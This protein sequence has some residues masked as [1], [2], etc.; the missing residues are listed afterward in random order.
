VDGAN[1]IQR[2]KDRDPAALAEIYVRYQPA[3]YRCIFYRVGDAGTA[4]DLTGEV[5]VRLVENMDRFPDQDGQ[6]LA[7]LCSIA[8][9]LTSDGHRRTGRSPPLASEEGNAGAIHPQEATEQRLSPQHLAAAIARL[10]DDQSQAVLL[11]FLEGLDNETVA[12]VLGQPVDAVQSLQWQALA[13]LTAALACCDAT[14]APQRSGPREEELERLQ[15][16]FTQNVAHELRTPLTLIQGYNEL[17]LTGTLGPL[18]SEQQ[19]ALEVVC[20]RIEELSRVIHSL[21]FTRAIPADALA[22]AP[23]SVPE[24]LENALNQYRHIAERAG[25]Q[26]ET[27]LPDE[28]PLALGDQKRLGVAFSQML[29]NAVKFS[30]DG[31]LVRVRAWADEGWVY[32]AVQDQGIGIAPEHLEAV[33]DRF[34]QVDG[35]ATRRFGG[36]GMGLAV[37]RAIADAHNGR[38]WASSEGLGKGSIFTLALPVRPAESPASSRLLSPERHRLFEQGLGQALDECLSLL[39]E[40]RATLDECLAHYPEYSADLRP[41]LETALKV[42]RAPRPAPSHAAF[43]AGE[44]LMLQALAEKKRA[45]TVSPSPLARCVE[46]FVD[47]FRRL[48]GPAVSRR[49][50]ALQPALAVALALV[51]LVFSGWSLLTWFGGTVAQ[52]GTL[53]QVKGAVEILPVGSEAW[54]LSS[55]GDRIESGDRIRTGSFSAATLVFFDGSTTDMRANTEATVAQMSS[56]RGGRGKVIVLHQWLGQTYNRVN[57]LRDETSH[58]RVET[59]TAVTAVRGTE[60]AIAIESNGATRVAVVEGVVNVTAEETTVA[61]LAGQETRVL[62]EQSPLAARPIRTATP[63]PW[64]TPSPTPPAQETP[65]HLLTPEPTQESGPTEVAE[66]PRTPTPS[67]VVEFPR[68]PTPSATLEPTEVPRSTETPAPA[69]TP[70]PRPMPTQWRSTPTPLPTHTPTPTFTPTRTSTPTPTPTR[71]S[72]PTPTPSSTPTATSTPTPTPTPT[73]TPT[74]TPTRTSTPT[75]TPSSTPTATSTPTPTA[76]PT[77]VPTKTHTPTPTATATFTPTATSTLTPTA[78][79]AVAPTAKHTPTPTSGTTGNV[80]II[81]SFYDGTDS[82]EPDEHIDIRNDDTQPIQ[83]NGWTLR[84]EAD[85]VFTFPDFVIQPG[86]VCRVYTGED[87]PEWCG[88][89]YGSDLAIWSNDG[90]CA[91][92]GDSA[93]TPIHTYCY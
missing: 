31:G 52:T 64:S 51:L 76:T 69:L 55:V 29:H 35:S 84:N 71:T 68:T 25:I 5:F 34:Y 40:S 7:W 86:Q 75:P 67:E 79:S 66:L 41:L 58:F 32:V 27:D 62:P 2:V 93:G 16:E 12:W 28:L 19:D 30:P 10:T 17:L 60:F 82:Q 38:V 9:D 44:R 18:Q 65:D 70:T 85:D 74:P 22:L 24:S 11:K 54:R 21:T 43:A 6:L 8:H 14:Q 89:N 53:V 39:E 42:R 3:V 56:R 26:F 83:L 78:I 87:H 20:E 61:V 1:L 50:L 48:E 37:V 57:R 59:P 81:D 23:V 80:V 72:T 77:V 47:L 63:T 49:S 46:W 36:V 4:E 13:A 91:Y 90:D 15:K 33:F 92:L 88:F 73:S 45:Q